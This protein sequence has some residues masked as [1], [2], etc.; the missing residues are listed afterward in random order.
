MLKEVVLHYVDHTC[1]SYLIDVGKLSMSHL[2][3]ECMSEESDNEDG[4]KTRH[5]PK[6]RSERKFHTLLCLSCIPMYI[7]IYRTEH[8]PS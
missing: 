2:S 3:K 7:H 5:T 6:W 8:I 1:C 4:T